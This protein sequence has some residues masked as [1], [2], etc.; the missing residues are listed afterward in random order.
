M[1]SP[2]QSI[3]TPLPS[4]KKFGWFFVFV[5]AVVAAYFYYKQITPWGAVFAGAMV[6]TGFIALLAPQWLNVPNRLW[7]GLGMLLGRIVSPIVLGVIFFLLITPVALVTRLGGRDVL[8]L[9]KRTVT[10][11]WIDRE[12]VGPAADS[13]KNQF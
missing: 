5:F 4:N 8:R 3:E 9:K 7:F 2:S 1:S 11:Y 13:F 12:P 6:L 10:S